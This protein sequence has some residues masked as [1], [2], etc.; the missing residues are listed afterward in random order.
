MAGKMIAAPSRT[1][2]ILEQYGLKA[3]K[4]YGQN[5][6]V[7]PQLVTRMAQEAHAEGAVLEIGPGLGA[8]TEALAQHSRHVRC[9]EIDPA[10]VRVLQDTLAGYENVEIREGDFLEADIAAEEKELR[11]AYGMVSV[12]ANLPYYI[13]SPVL[14]KIFE[15]T[16][17]PWLTVMVQKEVG[18]RFAAAPGSASYSALSVEGQYLYR[19]R[20]LFQVPARSFNPSPAVDSIV[21]Q[22]ERKSQLPQD[23]D[24]AG[25][26]ALVRACF[27]QRRKTLANNLRAELGEKR[28]VEEICRRAGLSPSVRAQNLSVAE[29]VRLY[30]VLKEET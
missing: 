28:E 27:R 4:G 14:F 22:F 15:Q 1:K 21:L 9:W 5:F 10:M 7:D 8:L 30:E 13:T 29:L 17:I 24:T 20:R 12:C 18:E 25:F 16:T 19:I 3:K 2:E 26:F 6:L 11:Q 23:V